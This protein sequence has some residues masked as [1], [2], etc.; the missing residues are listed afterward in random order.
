MGVFGATVTW[1]ARYDGVGYARVSPA[2]DNEVVQLAALRAAGV[3]KGHVVV[4]H[5]S[6]ARQHRPVLDRLLA[7]LVEGDV[8]VVG[9]LDPLARSVSHLVQTVEDLG[10][11]GVAFRSRPPP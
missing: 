7:G 8:L 10:A 5:A 9:K 2:D 6:G 11:R 3:G 1:E 4:E